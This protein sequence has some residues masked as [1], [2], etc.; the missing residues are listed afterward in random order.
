MECE[1]GPRSIR[2]RFAAFQAQLARASAFL[3]EGSFEAAAVHAQIAAHY[4][5][6]RHS[7]LFVSPRLERILLTIGRMC[8]EPDPGASKRSVGAALPQRVLHVFTRAYGVGGYT[9]MVWRWMQ[10]DHTRSHSVVLTR[11]GAVRVPPPL[12]E[13][14]AATGGRV[15]ALDGRPGTLISWAGALRELAIAADV[16]VL[17]VHPSDVIPVL[18][19]ADKRGTP[20]VVYL[21]HADQVFWV[22]ASVADVVASLRESGAQLAQTRRGIAAE[23]CALL[24]IALGP[25]G[26]PLSRARAK[27]ELGLAA[28]TVLMVSIARPQKYVPLDDLSYPGAVL[29]LL[30]RYERAVLLVVGPGDGGA[31]AGARQRTQGRVRALGMREDTA[32][33]YQ[34]ADIYVNS[35]PNPSITSLLEAGGYGTPLVSR[36]LHQAERSVLCADTPALDRCLIR[37]T[38]LTSYRKELARLI[39]DGELRRCLGEQTRQ[40]IADVHSGQAWRLS[41][42]ALYQRAVSVPTATGLPGLSDQPCIEELDVLLP[43]VFKGEPDLNEIVKSNLRLLPLDLR[44]RAWVKLLASERSAHPGLLLP[45]SLATR[46]ERWRYPRGSASLHPEAA[47]RSRRHAPA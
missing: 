22:G 28:D 36:C 17:H 3:K 19:F 13:A 2:Q 6:C 23:R 33:F 34:A 1:A 18:A 46:L 5:S 8:I 44:L 29:P 25:V 39:E 10:L 45:D 27:Q 40:A 42:E 7:G 12:M 24:P 47:P 37:A 11:Q 35:F 9:R 32:L 43:Q 15:T 41:L 4:A 31:W 21:D 26:R 16:V 38:D 30:E 20:P 14:A